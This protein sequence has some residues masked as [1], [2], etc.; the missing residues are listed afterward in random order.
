MPQ[1]HRSSETAK[2][3]PELG[4]TV[5]GGL[6]VVIQTPSEIPGLIDLSW[7]SS[8]SEVHRALLDPSTNLEKVEGLRKF[9]LGMGE[10]SEFDSLMEGQLTGPM[11]FVPALHAAQKI[12]LAHGQEAELLRLVLLLPEIEGSEGRM[13]A[14]AQRPVFVIRPGSLVGDFI[15]GAFRV[16]IWAVCFVASGGTTTSARR[17]GMVQRLRE[18]AMKTSST[19]QDIHSLVTPPS[20]PLVV[21]IH[22]LF[23]TDV[24]TFGTLQRLLEEHFEIV[25]FPHDTLTESIGSNALE[26]ARLLGRITCDNIHLVAHSRGGLVAR[27]AITLL[28]RLRPSVNIRRCV[29]FGTP[30]LGAELAENPGSLIFSVALLKT[31]NDGKSGASLLDALSCFSEKGDFPGI[32]DLCPPSSGAR[33]LDQLQHDEGLYPDEMVDLFAVGGAKTPKN[34][35][36]HIA[37]SAMHRIIG[38]GPNDLVVRQESSLPPL[39]RPTSEQHAVSCDHFGYFDPDQEGTLQKAV[40][41]LLKP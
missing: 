41:F 34:F 16:P 15:R 32:R 26:L 30:H 28:R 8:I 22:G 36:Q 1:V 24:G 12:W 2:D 25:G 31:G 3:L 20:R 37:E 7:G 10:D 17:A 9:L 27:S 13:T 4:G 21:L 35:M 6:A 11:S 29:T 14:E 23:A 33:W 38:N 40:N 5:R 18:T 19:L 39:G